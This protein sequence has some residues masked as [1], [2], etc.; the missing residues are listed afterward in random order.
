MLKHDVKDF[1]D[2]L[3][4]LPLRDVG[5]WCD[6]VLNAEILLKE[7][8]EAGPFA[9]S[10]KRLCQYLD[11]AE[12]TLSGWLK[13]DRIPRLAKEAYSWRLDLLLLIN[14][15]LISAKVKQPYTVQEAMAFVVS[16]SHAELDW[17]YPEGL[18]RREADHGE[19]RGLVWSEEQQ[20]KHRKK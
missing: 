13:E 4:G 15:V 9:P 7:I 5:E 17:S 10:R 3:L 18:R 19:K 11:I 2:Q 8:E 16:H 14:V 12:S 1:L 6:E 20:Q